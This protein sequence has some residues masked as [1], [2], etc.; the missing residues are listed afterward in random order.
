MSSMNEKNED[1]LGMATMLNT[2]MKSMGD[3]W[4]NMAGQWSAAPGQQSTHTKADNGANT[5]G[6]AAVATA[7]KNWQTVAGAMAAPESIAS[8]FKGSGAMPEVLLKLSQNSMGS[9]MEMQQKMIQR[10]GRIGESVE[11]YQFQGID[12]NMF[13]AWTDIYLKEFQQFFQIPQL[14]LMR[15]YQEKANQV[16]DKYNLF[17]STL[18]EFLSLLGLPFNR[19][20]QVMQEKLGEMAEKGDLSDDTKVYYNMWVKVLEGHFMT[21]FQTPEYVD[22]LTRTVN[23]LADF[24]AARNAA[25]EDLLNMLPV[26][27]KTEMDDMAREL[28]E[29]KKRLRKLEKAQK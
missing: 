6:Q 24:S 25:L 8:L 3:L 15:T 20:M 14:G 17:Q 7:L 27:K 2:W 13:R 23:A 11:A 28:Y 22:T 12:E 26:A 9:F 19:S 1:P 29:L 16:A 21:L 18:S 10:V 4:G 5:R